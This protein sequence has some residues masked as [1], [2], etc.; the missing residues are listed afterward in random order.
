MNLFNCRNCKLDRQWLIESAMSVAFCEVLVNCFTFKEKCSKD[1]KPF[2][3]SLQGHY[4]L[5]VSLNNLQVYNL[6]I[7]AFL[8]ALHYDIKHRDRLA[9]NIAVVAG[10]LYTLPKE[11]LEKFV[12]GHYCLVV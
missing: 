12:G 4:L 6:A 1:H 9:D 5:A 8:N 11:T 10:N 2:V 3:P 7:S